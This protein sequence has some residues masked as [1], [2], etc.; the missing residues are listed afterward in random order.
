MR[1]APFYP[2]CIFRVE[3]RT[4]RSP[5]NSYL[6]QNQLNYSKIWYWY[7]VLYNTLQSNGF[8]KFFMHLWQYCASK[9]NWRQYVSSKC[10]YCCVTKRCYPTCEGTTHEAQNFRLETGKKYM[11]CYFVLI[12]K[13]NVKANYQCLFVIPSFKISEHM[14]KNVKFRSRFDHFI[15][16]ISH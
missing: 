6:H 5:S 14:D 12:T 13:C 3:G 4:R 1:S 2:V 15:V 16:N 10:L 7:V 8:F 11:S 9:K